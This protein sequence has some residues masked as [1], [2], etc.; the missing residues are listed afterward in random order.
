MGSATKPGVAKNLSTRFQRVAAY[1][2]S[3]SS[4]RLAAVSSL[5]PAS[6]RPAGNSHKNCSAAWRYWRS[7]RILGWALLSSSARMTTDPEWRTISRRTRTP[8]GSM[9]SSEVTQ[10]TGPRYTSREESTRALAVLRDDLGMYRIY[11]TAAWS[12]PPANCLILLATV[13]G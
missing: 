4:S 11:L 1:P 8:A 12:L 10:K 9:T 2:V 5:S 13:R 7:S 3:S 6:M